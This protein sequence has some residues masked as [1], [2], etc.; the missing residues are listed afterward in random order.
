MAWPTD[1]LSVSELDQGTDKPWLART[2]ILTAVNKVKAIL[3]QRGAAGGI[4]PL[5]NDSK[6][7]IGNIPTGAGTGLNADTLRGKADTDFAGASHVGSGGSS[8]AL[9]TQAAAGFMSTADKV[10]L[11]SLTQGNQVSILTGVVAH[12]ATIPLPP[13]YTQAQ[14]KWFVGP[15]YFYSAGHPYVIGGLDFKASAARVV[16]AQYRYDTGG[17]GWAWAATSA[18]YII[19]GVK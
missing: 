17:S 16:T 13:G 12:G 7:P 11:D 9:A 10:K 14:C 6:V 8:H 15:E 3:A 5:D 18:N 19:I 2:Q 4:A 1:D